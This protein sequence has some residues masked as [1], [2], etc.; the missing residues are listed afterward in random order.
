M[1]V[2]GR[3]TNS[4]EKVILL[5]FYLYKERPK[6]S[7]YVIPVMILARTSPGIWMYLFKSY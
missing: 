6:R 7:P 5:A 4:I 1:K 2:F 3:D